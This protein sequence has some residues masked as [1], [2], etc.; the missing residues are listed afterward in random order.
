MKIKEL[1]I[2]GITGIKEEISLILN[3]NSLLLFGDN[4]GG[5]SSISDAIE[6]F[7]WDKVK[8][9][10]IGEIDR[11]GGISA[12]RNIHLTKEQNAEVSIQ[13]FNNSSFTKK[14]A[15][16]LQSTIS[17]SNNTQYIENSQKENLILR[18][19]DLTNFI[20]VSKTEKLKYLSSIIL[21]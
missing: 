15:S 17:S 16:N 10:S 13:F 20:L 3:G 9:L 11:K 14:L 6:W 2:T 8:I 5:K 19:S 7:Y 18:Y 1:K 12:L 4:G 21:S